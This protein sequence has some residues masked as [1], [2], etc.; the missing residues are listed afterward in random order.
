MKKLNTTR[1][2]LHFIAFT[3]GLFLIIGSG[4][5]RKAIPKETGQFKISIFPTA[6]NKETKAIVY[7]IQNEGIPKRVLQ[8]GRISISTGHG[9]GIVN[10]DKL[11]LWLKFKTEGFNSDVKVVSTDPSYDN[12][13]Q[14]FKEALNPGLSKSVSVNFDIPREKL[15]KK[16]DISSGNLLVVDSRSGKILAKVPFKIVNSKFKRNT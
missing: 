15:N 8:P 16:Y 2:L 1:V 14:S 6:E 7:D 4:F 10:K 3:V 5:Y 11:P 13:T 9:G 12:K